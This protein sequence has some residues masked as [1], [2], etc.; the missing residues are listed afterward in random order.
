MNTGIHHP[1]SLAALVML[2]VLAV[3]GGTG[4]PGRPAAP[5]TPADASAPASAPRPATAKVL[6]RCLKRSAL[7]KCER[8]APAASGGNRAA[9]V[10]TPAPT[11]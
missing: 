8:R 7:G 6:P 10:A 4:L 5:A 3:L 11:R 1:Y 2:A 9:P